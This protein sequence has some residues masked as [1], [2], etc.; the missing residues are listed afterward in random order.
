MVNR[1]VLIGRHA[2]AQTVHRLREPVG[3]HDLKRSTMPLAAVAMPGPFVRLL[4]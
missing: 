3:G 4:T 2:R 1:H